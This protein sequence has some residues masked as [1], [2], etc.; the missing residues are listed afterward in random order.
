MKGF[1]LTL[2]ALFALLVVGTGVSILL[3][4]SYSVPSPYYVQYSSSS[5][6]TVSLAT[7][8]FSG[9]TNIPLVSD[10]NKQS[11]AYNQS[12]N[13]GQNNPQNDAGNAGG[14][15]ALTL[16]NDINVSMPINT[17]SIT[18]GYGNVYFGAGNVLYAYNVTDGQL[19]WE[20]SAPYYPDVLSTPFVNVTLLYQNMLIYMTTANIVAVNPINGS[21][22]WS[23]PIPYQGVITYECAPAPPTCGEVEPDGDEGNL[24]LYPINGR[25]V[26]AVTDAAPSPY[27]SQLYSF[28]PG[29]GT[30]ASIQPLQANSLQYM[31]ITAGQIA[32]VYYNPAVTPSSWLSLLTQLINSTYQG[33]QIWSVSCSSE[34]I[35]GFSAYA[36]VIAYGCGSNA[37]INRIDSKTVSSYSVGSSKDITGV[38]IFNGRIV[39]QST[40]EIDMFNI[41]GYHLW[42]FSVPKASYGSAINNATPALSSK[43]VYT[44]WNGGYLLVNNL[45]TS[46]LGQAIPL[47]YP[48]R[49][50]PYMAVAYGRLFVSQ[51]TNLMEFGTCSARPNDSVL[52]ALAT[53]YW[54]GQGSCAAY[55][56]STIAPSLNYTIALDGQFPESAAQFN[57]ATSA[58]YIPNTKPLILT[59]QGSIVA[60][61]NEGFSVPVYGTI[62]SKGNGGSDGYKLTLNDHSGHGPQFTLGGDAV[63]FGTA[64]SEN[65]WYM[66]TATWSGTGAN[67]AKVCVDA[68]CQ[69]YT[70]PG[71]DIPTAGDGDPLYMGLA[72][73]DEY[74]F[75]GMM[76]N[77]QIYNTSLSQLQ[78]NHL[79]TT[80][81]NAQPLSFSNL[82]AWFPLQGDANSYAGTYIA[83]FPINLQ[84]NQILYNLFPSAMPSL[85]NTYSI[86][87]QSVPLQLFNYSTDSYSLYNVGVYTWK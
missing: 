32:D 57:G 17:G 87:G 45:S 7:S 58:V 76:A 19:V 85:Q 80:G 18:A 38:S 46:N 41:S 42:S 8:K 65:T 23:Q 34:L 40:Q 48:G 56:L 71:G 39:F 37:D 10:I 52:A 50:N 55:L 26:A 1:V 3:Y 79:Y 51:G 22:I 9:I 69:S 44:L 49:I 61:V 20:D 4:F 5:S 29:N 83:G 35:N 81:V 36:N 6:A 66:V 31:A 21:T 78:I 59:S 12:W 86:T 67:N 14:P 13:M 73:G 30:I 43:N 82:A 70:I 11:Y 53:M 75:N 74:A 15:P 64:L 24:L 68:K 25:V 77:V 54:N 47:P 33:G 84:Y 72:N 28:Y 60:W 16:E 62:V 27:L 2:D 63:T